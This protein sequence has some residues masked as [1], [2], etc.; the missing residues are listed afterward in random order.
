M[1]NGNSADYLHSQVVRIFEYLR[2]IEG[3]P[4]VV[5]DTQEMWMESNIPI[6]S[7]DLGSYL[8]DEDE[9]CMNYTE[10]TYWE[11]ISEQKKER[12]EN[13]SYFGEMRQIDRKERIKNQLK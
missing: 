5:G 1:S 9:D 3:S 11:Q 7:S 10:K 6:F 13:D 4:N 2:L 12:I 8:D